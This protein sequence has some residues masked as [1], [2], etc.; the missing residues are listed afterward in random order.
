[1]VASIGFYSDDLTREHIVAANRAA[2]LVDLTAAWRSW[3]EEVGLESPDGLTYLAIDDREKPRRWV[4][5]PDLTYK[6]GAA[7]I[8]RAEADGRLVAEWLAIFGEMFDYWAE[9]KG[10]DPHPP[11][12]DPDAPLPPEVEANLMAFY[13]NQVLMDAETE[14]MMELLDDD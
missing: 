8:V 3:F 1:M 12:P 2:M 6:V 10:T 4:R 5:G 7:R 9:K 14:L 11:L 13:G